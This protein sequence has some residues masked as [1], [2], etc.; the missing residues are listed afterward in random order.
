M[1]KP[2]DTYNERLEFSW[3]FKDYAIRTIREDWQNPNSK[4]REDCPIELIKY[5]DSTH[6]SCY[7]IGLFHLDDEGYE[8]RSIGGRLFDCI[9]AEDIAEIWAQL[10]AGQKMLDAYYE[11]CCANERY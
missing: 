5:N 8:L 7:V 3:E 10:Q 4:I 6:K 11:A 9:D 1:G 2:I